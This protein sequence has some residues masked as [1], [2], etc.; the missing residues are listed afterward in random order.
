ML[1]KAHYEPFEP[2]SVDEILD[3]LL[4]LNAIFGIMTVASMILVVFGEVPLARV[5]PHWVE[6]I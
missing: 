5:R 4:Q 2:S 6:S 3:L 1:F